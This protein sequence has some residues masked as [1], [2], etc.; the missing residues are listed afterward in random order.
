MIAENVY[1]LFHPENFD[2]NVLYN[3]KTILMPHQVVPKYYLLSNPDIHSLIIN[4]T[5]G[6][7]KSMTAVFLILKLL[8]EKRNIEFNSQFV[9]VNQNSFLNKKMKAEKN[10][11]VISGWQGVNAICEELIKPEFGYINDEDDNLLRT[12]PSNEVKSLKRSLFKGMEQYI[13]FFG[14]QAFFNFCFPNLVNNNLAQDAKALM[15]EYE[16]DNIFINEKSKEHLRDSIIIIDEMQ[17]L[18][19]VDGL[20]SYGF[21]VLLL[22]KLAKEL[23]CKIMLMTG[24]IINSSIREIIDICNITSLD[25]KF[26]NYDDYLVEKNNEFNIKTFNIK[27]D[28]EIELLRT[29][30]KNYIAYSTRIKRKVPELIDC[31]KLPMYNYHDEG[32]KAF[33]FDKQKNLPQEIYIGNTVISKDDIDCSLIC[34]SLTVEGFQKDAYKQYI[35]NQLNNSTNERESENSNTM[36]IQDAYIPTKDA[37]KHGIIQT[38]QCYIGKFLSLENIRKFS[39]AGYTFCKMCLEN[40]WHNEKTIVYHSNLRNFGIYQYAKILEANGF[41]EI[42][43][44]IKENSLCKVCKHEYSLHR[45]SIE[46]R[47]KYKC[48]NN[49]VPLTFG[50]MTG[51]NSQN[52][53]E[54]LLNIY[55]A[56]NNLYGDVCSVI[57]V[58]NVAYSGVSFLNTNNLIMISRISDISKW[59][60]IAARIVRTK[61]HALLPPEKHYAKIYTF[62]VNYP[63]EC[64]VFPKLKGLTIG[65]KYYKTN[66]ILN[67]DVETF[68]NK[69]NKFC[70]GNVLLNSPEIYEMSETEEKI[71]NNLLRNDIEYELNYALNK[72]LFSDDVNNVWSFDTLISRV[73]NYNFSFIDFT[74]IQP[75]IIE[76]IIKKNKNIELYSSDKGNRIIKFPINSDIELENPNT[77]MFETINNFTRNPKHLDYLLNLLESTDKLLQSVDILQRI[78]KYLKNNFALIKDKQIFWNKMFFIHNEYYPDDETNFF[79]NHCKKNRNINKM[80]GFYYGDY[81][82]FKD[83]TL[84]VINY[85][86]PEPK[87]VDKL[88]FYFKITSRIST[89]SSPFYL[90]VSVVKQQEIKEDNR[91]NPKGVDCFNINNF[92]DFRK[93]FPE[94]KNI[95]NKKDFCRELLNYLCE[96]QLKYGEKYKVVFSPFEK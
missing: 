5:M 57:F 94:L 46:E 64:K 56:P 89:S 22:H 43:N 76:D 67:K 40:S 41:I 49:F 36:Y 3:R 2:M 87:L 61:S 13:N 63:D 10:I 26:L 69:L 58:S 38:N 81:I 48:C 54:E 91:K 33:V 79:E 12:L 34:Y 14:Y 55:N 95:E 74:R 39:I 96:E 51:E 77:F 73:N 93:Y 84:K 59:K 50:L 83:A 11:I 25:R 65:A 72:D 15:I 23:N 17:K 88:P 68:L 82:V 44:P 4:Y 85:K 18:Y 1:E 19:S 24:T 21:N 70:T 32:C 62:I 60:Q 45:K 47:L 37:F 78:L 7:G 75:E 53:R 29:L 86:F 71:T 20:N 92:N 16:K 27:E 52:D 90:R 42:G 35:E 66:Y 9:K 31:D 30:K 8:N 28:K 6:T 80:T